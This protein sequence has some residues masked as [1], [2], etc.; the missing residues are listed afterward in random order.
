MSIFGS[1]KK[2]AAF[3]DAF[4]EHAKKSV[5]AAQMLVAMLGRMQTGMGFPAGLIMFGIMNWMKNK[6]GAS[7][8]FVPWQAEN[9]SA[10]TTG[11]E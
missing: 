7:V 2:D 1:S 8:K 9:D 3:F 11:A 4:T 10:H 5:E 6:S